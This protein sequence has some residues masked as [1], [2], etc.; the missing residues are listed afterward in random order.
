[1]MAGMAVETM[2]EST[3]IM[4]NPMTRAQSAVQAFLSSD[5]WVLLG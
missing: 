2:V 3:K 1:M 5:S 4:K